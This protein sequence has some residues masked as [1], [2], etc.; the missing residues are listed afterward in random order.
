MPDWGFWLPLFVLFSSLATGVVIFLLPEHHHRQRS[1]L[2][3]GGATAKVVFVGIVTWGVFHG[4]EFETRLAFMP[5]IDLLLRVDP[6][7]LIFI[8]LSAGLWLLTTLYAIGYLEGSPHRSRF[9]GFFSICVTA[10]MGIALAGNLLTFFIF[11]EL[12]TAATYP[13]VVHRGTAKSLAAGRTYLLYTLSGG[14]L[15][16][17]G[18]VWLHVHVGPVEFVTGGALRDLSAEQHGPLVPI[19]GLLIVGLGVKAALV[20]LHS[21]L[22]EAMIAPAPVSALLHAV[23]VVKAG[24]YGILRTVHDLYGVELADTLGVLTPLAVVASVTIVYGSLRALTQQELKRRLAYSTVSQVSYIALGAAIF[25]PLA[26]TG[27]LVHLMH[28]GLMKV[29]L[30]FCAGN[31]AE[32]LGIH[33]VSQVDGVGH[34]MPLTMV[35]FTVAAFGMMGVPPVAGF[36][37]KWYLGLGALQGD[38]GWILVVLAGSSLLNAAYFLPIVYRAWFRPPGLPWSEWARLESAWMLLLPALGTA[39]LALAAGLLAGTP[40]SPLSLAELAVESIYADR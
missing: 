35:A 27:A 4:E 21:W 39:T 12:L 32:T 29:T 19:F 15:L 30:F 9:F 37:S 5:G 33:R 24:A 34:R 18:T 6:I 23:A 2:N 3:M 31:L 26:T 16:L 22:P 1:L 17:A 14:I 8:V 7:S 20:P 13:L 25:A 40:F 38:Q 11:Y 28:Q 10:T 36:V